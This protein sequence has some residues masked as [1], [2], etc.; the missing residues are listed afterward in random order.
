[1]SMSHLYG[2]REEEEDGV[3]IEKFE[4]SEWDLANEF[5]PERRRHKQ[6]KE[7]ATYGIWAEH[8]SDEERPSFGGKR[9]K[10]YSAPVSFVSAGIRKTA[11]EEKQEQGSDESDADGEAPPAPPPS[12]AAAPK[13]LQTGSNFKSSQ[14]GFAGNIRPGQDL[15]TWEKHTRGIGQKL[16]QKMGYVAGQGLGKNAQGIVNPIEAKVRKG[17]G[18]VGAYGRERTQQSLQDFPVVDSEE[19]E[20]KE[21][22][23]ELGQWRREPGVGKKKPKYSYRTVEELKAHG[24][25]SDRGMVTPAGEL[26]KVKVIDMTG[27]EQ[28]VY[29][30][31][32]QMSQKHSVPEEPTLSEAVREQKPSGFALPELEHNLKLLIE[33]T[34]QEILQSARQL[35]HE[36]DTVVSLSHESSVLQER[37]SEE[38]AALRRL[39]EVLELVERF[40]AGEGHGD[41]PITLQECA[42]VFEKL[43][44]GFYQEYKT[45]GL[46]DLAVSVLHPLLKG[47]LSS[48]NPLKDCSY[49][50]EEVGQW[51]AILESGQMH[52]GAPDASNMDPYHRLLWE[53][54]LP[55]MRT[56]VTQWQPRNVGPMVDCIECWAPI[57]PLWI[58]DHVL[59]Q[60]IFPRLQREVESWNPLTDTVPIHAWLHPWLP[61]LQG[62]L[63]PLYPPIRSKLANALQ[64][65]HPSDGSARLI[66][67]PWKDV[68]TPG[69]WE[70]FMVK[71]IVPK[72][73]LCLSELVVNP[74][75][76]H[77]DPFHWVMDWEG[78]LSPS[79]MVGLLDKNFFRKWL[80][81]LCSWLSNSPNYEEIT[82]WYLGWKSMFSDTLLAQPLVKD[83]FNEALDIMNRAVSSGIGDYMQPGARENIA[84]LTHTERRRDFQYRAAQERQEAESAAQRGIGAMAVP[85]N[86]KD[87]V[88]AKAVENGIVFLPLVGRRHEGKQLYTLG[89][90]TVYIDRG[91]VFVQGERTWVPTSLQSIIDMAK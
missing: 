78:M 66:L 45:L 8:D 40:E 1:M 60:L 55:V 15:G 37:L 18:A 81:V 57:L 85:T 63:E 59:E 58:L 33:L 28:R 82:K 9:S 17:K 72:L 67:Q 35:Q 80:Q 54:W 86:F 49:G 56:A 3:E 29:Y 70:A 34:E 77:M 42:E 36:R 48:W 4:I 32:S 2:R 16:L 5:N 13:K 65:W 91:V 23:K 41:Q 62:R 47:K 76:Q 27:R 73:E 90:I 38:D 51:R 7:E 53:V 14:R 84:Y 64:R 22:Q 30:S 74:H 75:Q 44:T 79:C 26:A 50:L 10:D 25:V 43:Q 6:T 20:E 52:H 68:F 31:Y 46:S 89:R 21:F 83:K 24:K 19:E 87:L 11:A 12:R 71:N 39:E 88:Q 69:A 61:L